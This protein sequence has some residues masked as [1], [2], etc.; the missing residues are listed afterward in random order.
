MNQS[1]EGGHLAALFSFSLDFHIVIMYFIRME[2]PVAIRVFGAVIPTHLLFEV[3]A[4]VVAFLVH[5]IQP[6]IANAPKLNKDQRLWVLAG[7]LIGAALGARI[8]G[9][10][11]WLGDPTAPNVLSMLGHKTIVGGLLGGWVGIEIAKKRMGVK[12]ATGDRYVLPL[13][14]AI[15]VGRIGCF[16]TGLED[17]TIGVHS[18]LP[19]AINFGDG[20]RHPSPL[21]EIV[22]LLLLWPMLLSVKG[23]MKI[24][25]QWFR[26][27]LMAYLTFRLFGDFIKP[28]IERIAYLSSIQIACVVG[29][30][31]CIRSWR[32]LTPPQNRETDG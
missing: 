17:R 5:R 25:G 1:E 32:R 26:I 4:F 11:E 10:L 21:Y 18:S 24:A 3:L 14:F 22:F 29:L 13:L 6:K 27:F 12:T 28:R 20:T 31:A 9:T 8:L 16:L 15:A 2:F 19:W 23:R 7:A 30:T